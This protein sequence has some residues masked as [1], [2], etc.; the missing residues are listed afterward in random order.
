MKEGDK[1]LQISV[2]SSVH[3]AFCVLGGWGM[4]VWA[5]EP[6]RGRKG[7]RICTEWV[8]FFSWAS[9]AVMIVH[10]CITDSWQKFPFKSWTVKLF[11]AEPPKKGNGLT[12]VNVCFSVNQGWCKQHGCVMLTRCLEKRKRVWHADGSS[13]SCCKLREN[14]FH[15]ASSLMRRYFIKPGAI[16]NQS[17]H[18]EERFQREMQFYLSY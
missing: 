13:W 1:K 18:S 10:R 16:W 5:A 14:W 15:P 12:A 4:S 6:L 17:C 8:Q 2:G 9:A 11:S 3:P 7:S